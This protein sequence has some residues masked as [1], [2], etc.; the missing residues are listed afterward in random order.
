MITTRQLLRTLFV[1]LYIAPAYSTAASAEAEVKDENELTALLAH[2]VLDEGQSLA[3][4][5]KFCDRRIAAMP[6]NLSWSAWQ[7]EADR[8]QRTVLENVVFRNVPP[9]WRDEARRIEWLDTIPGGPGYRIKKLRYEA[10][11]GL[12]IPALLYEPERLDGRVPVVLNVNGHDSKGKQAP[13][14]QLRCINVAKRGMLA[15]NVEWLGMGQ[16]QGDGFAH[17]RMNQLDLCGTSGLAVFYLVMERALDLLVD[18]PHADV[19]RVAMA[20]LSGGGWQTSLFSSLDRRVTLSNPVAGYSSFKTR[21]QFFSD[22]G[23]SE[24]TPTDLAVTAD[25]KH[26]TAM[27]APRPTLLTYNAKDECCFASAHAL[28]PLLDAAK[29][30]FE[31]AGAGGRL[32]SHVNEDPGTHNFERENREQ[33]YKMLGDHFYAGVASYDSKEIDSEGEV[34]SAEELNVPLPDENLDFHKLAVQLTAELPAHKHEQSANTK[35]QAAASKPTA[36]SVAG[37]ARLASYELAA[38]MVGEKTAGETKARFWRIKLDDDW[39][40][41]VVE[42]TRG[43]PQGTCCVLADGGR[44]AA[45]EQIESLLAER[46]RMLAIDPF[47]LGES[48]IEQRGYL[49]ALLVSSVGARPVGVQADQ[50]QAVTRWANSQ[51]GEPVTQH[52]AIGPRVALAALLAAATA[53]DKERPQQL[54]LHGS[55][56]S[57]R[58]VIENNWSVEEYPEMFCFGLL[59]HCDVDDLVEL[60]KPCEVVRK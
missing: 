9:A 51:F 31:L 47:Y 37:I 18:H 16:L 39:T 34:K 38:V 3:E 14:K 7:R 10:L 30:I 57:L 13:Y 44:T 2:R 46:H 40:V 52:T 15:L 28:P 20:G 29:P 54:V 4:V 32:R 27:R 48:K 49:F 19:E 12:W 21:V 1:L 26:L 42:L 50:L 11:P 41:P 25:Y 45:S 59:Q 53:S 33:F 24:Q 35:S 56:G 17:G 58:E 5:Q 22:L 8:L 6:Q 23:D 60:A 43:T 55:I 36:H